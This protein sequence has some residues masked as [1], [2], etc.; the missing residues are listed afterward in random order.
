MKLKIRCFSSHFVLYHYAKIRSGL[1]ITVL[2]KKMNTGSRVKIESNETSISPNPAKSYL[3]L[4]NVVILLKPNFRR[5]SVKRIITLYL[6][7]RVLCSW[8]LTAK[9]A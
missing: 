9:T 4:I 8:M 1:S 7:I 6:V 2:E 5:K 3:S